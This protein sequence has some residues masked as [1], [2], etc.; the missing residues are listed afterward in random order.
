MLVHEWLASG[1]CWGAARV[2]V[3][4]AC[5]TYS[6]SRHTELVI[7]NG[8]GWDSFLTFATGMQVMEH[9]GDIRLGEHVFN[10]QLR[11]MQVYRE[12]GAPAHLTLPNFI[13]EVANTYTSLE[14]DA[15]QC[16]THGLQSAGPAL[17]Q[18]FAADF[19]QGPVVGGGVG[20]WLVDH[21]HLVGRGRDHLSRISK[22]CQSRRVQCHRPLFAVRAGVAMGVPC[23]GAR[24]GQRLRGRRREAYLG[25]EAT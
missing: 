8:I 3:M 1:E 7:S 10:K 22:A 21:S 24:R 13:N 4:D 16:L 19:V 11:E 20:G 25:A 2:E 12:S 6:L 15:V 23:A 17:R 18:Y 9:A 14:F 5:D